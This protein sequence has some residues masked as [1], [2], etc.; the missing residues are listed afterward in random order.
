MQLSSS[1]QSA[2]KNVSDYLHAPFENMYTNM[3][4]LF[5]ELI[6]RNHTHPTNE[7]AVETC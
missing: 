2:Y 7:S 4:V 6:Y 1:V 3:Y 5:T